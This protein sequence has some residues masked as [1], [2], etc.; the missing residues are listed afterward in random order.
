MLYVV[1]R[2]IDR[3]FRV[4]EVVILDY[5]LTEKNNVVRNNGRTF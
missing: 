4:I 2:L 1:V 5:T 3:C